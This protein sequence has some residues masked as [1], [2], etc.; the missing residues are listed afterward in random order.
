MSILHLLNQDV[1]ISRPTNVADGQ[2]GYKKTFAVS[3]AT[4]RAR[5][6][7]ASVTERERASR[8]ELR[9]SHVMYMETTADV[10]RADRILE[11]ADLARTMDVIQISH[12]SQSGHHL[13]IGLEQIVSGV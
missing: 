8:E 6:R 2:G 12:L 1:K 7:S 10:L 11:L 13:E 9:L 4:I 3:T 5:I